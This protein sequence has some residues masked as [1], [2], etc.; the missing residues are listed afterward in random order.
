MTLFDGAAVATG[1]GV[2]ELALVTYP[3]FVF[4]LRKF[5]F[6]EVAVQ[7]DNP[8]RTV[9]ATVKNNFVLI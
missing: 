2:S 1:L 3:V 7:P 5:A 6:C 9:A 8:Q 4:V